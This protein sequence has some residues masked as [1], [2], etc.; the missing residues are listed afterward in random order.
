MYVVVVDKL[1]VM[2]LIS[3]LYLIS[4]LSCCNSMSPEIVATI[5]G[6]SNEVLSMMRALLLWLPV[7]LSSATSHVKNELKSEIFSGFS[8]RQQTRHTIAPSLG[9]DAGDD[10][11]TVLLHPR[12]Y[13]LVGDW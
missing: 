3:S 8:K 4:I 11:E 5:T 9:V 1:I 12:L 2:G 7:L 10:D 6:P 13:L